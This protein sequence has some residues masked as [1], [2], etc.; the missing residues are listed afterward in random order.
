MSMIEV[1]LRQNHSLGTGRAL[2]ATVLS[3]QRLDMLWA[4]IAAHVPPNQ[5][6]TRLVKGYQPY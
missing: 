3:W 1:I 6:T 2:L 4:A 5:T